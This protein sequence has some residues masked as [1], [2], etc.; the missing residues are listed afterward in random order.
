LVAKEQ[1]EIW[2]PIPENPD[3]QVSNLGRVKSFK[4]YRN[5]SRRGNIL[6]GWVNQDGYR[7]VSIPY[8][9]IYKNTLVHILVCTAFNGL[10]SNTKYEVCHRDGNK[11]NNNPSNLRWDS[12]KSNS[13][14]SVKH[15]V[16]LRGTRHRSAKLTEGKV[17]EIRKLITQGI[18]HRELAAKFNV[19]P[20]SIYLIIKRTNW[21]WLD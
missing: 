7:M 12:H 3:Y 16:L 17:R 11:L 20:S 15:A 5:L 9:G 4:N 19:S 21:A 8:N 2:K 10:K 18:S 13:E 14:D 6:K 1:L